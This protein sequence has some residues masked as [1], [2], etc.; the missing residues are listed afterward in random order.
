[1]PSPTESNLR[2]NR[3]V[4]LIAPRLGIGKRQLVEKSLNN[5]K[6]KFL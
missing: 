3:Y 1:V 5:S 4:E 6:Y 2:N